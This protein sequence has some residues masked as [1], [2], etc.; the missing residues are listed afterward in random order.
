[1]GG[2]GITRINGYDLDCPGCHVSV[3]FGNSPATVLFATPTQLT[4]TAPPGHGTVNITVTVNGVTS[5]LT[6]AD[7]Y[8]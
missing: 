3:K 1:M 7:T 6:S 5:N 8:Y 2:G 4:V